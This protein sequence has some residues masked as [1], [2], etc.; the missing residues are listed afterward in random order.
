MQILLKL[1]LLLSVI[2][3]LITHITLHTE[4][5]YIVSIRLSTDFLTRHGL[6]EKTV[7]FASLLVTLLAP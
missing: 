7:G 1:E 3:L 6:G 4:M 2:S 5:A